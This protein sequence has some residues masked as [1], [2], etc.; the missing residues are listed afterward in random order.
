LANWGTGEVATIAPTVLLATS[1][2]AWFQRAR[3][4]AFW[5]GFGLAGWAYLA[6]SLGS[7]AGSYLPTT[8][9]LDGL[10]GQVYPPEAFRSFEDDFAVP[11]AMRISGDRFRRAGHSVF[12][13]LI[14]LLGGAGA[15]VLLPM[16]CEDRDERL[17][18]DGSLLNPRWRDQYDRL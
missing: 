3:R 2:L 5:V 8:R 12:S 10:H 7:P 4:R 18:P 9:M 6:L 15:S 11:R 14:A 13:L 1:V 17:P 16:R